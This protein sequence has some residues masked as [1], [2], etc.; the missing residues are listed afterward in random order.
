MEEQLP[1]EL[2]VVG[3][4]DLQAQRDLVGSGLAERGDEA[5]GAEPRGL[6]SR[7]ADPL[8]QAMSRNWAGASALAF[9]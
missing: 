7:T 5:L 2:L 4:A 6:P 3:P 8:E 9:Q 1:G